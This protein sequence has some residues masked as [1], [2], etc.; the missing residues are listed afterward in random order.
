[1][2]SQVH[3]VLASASPRRRELLAQTGVPFEVVAPTLPELRELAELPPTQQAEA[4]A[5]FKARTVH[6]ANPT[7][8]VLG[9]DTLVVLDRQVLGKPR[10]RDHARE[11]LLALTGTRHQV[12]TGVALLGPDRRL[13]ASDTTFVTMRKMSPQELNEYLDSNQWV[14]KAGAYGIQEVGDRFVT[15]IEG[16][17]SNVMGLPTELVTRMLHQALPP[18]EGAP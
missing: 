9:A 18:A 14:G 16:S 15:K 10:D 5:Y 11:I 4:L 7:R 13:I 12:I 8:W 2:Q 6:D 3:L 1:M 17:F